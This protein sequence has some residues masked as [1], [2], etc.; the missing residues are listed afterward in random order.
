M[1]HT[2]PIFPDKTLDDKALTRSLRLALAAASET[3]AGYEALADAAEN[4]LAELV[5]GDLADRVREN[6][7]ELLALIKLL[8]PD[9]ET[10]LQK[11][12][13]EAHKLAALQK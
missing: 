4:K 6:M 8:A 10:L 1:H 11:G 9:E 2:L 3:A 5:L 13:Q 7:G 12:A